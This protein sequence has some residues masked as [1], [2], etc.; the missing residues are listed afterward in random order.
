MVCDNESEFSLYKVSMSLFLLKLITKYLARKDRGKDKLHLLIHSFHAPEGIFH[1]IFFSSLINTSSQEANR[2]FE[3]NL[4]ILKIIIIRNQSTSAVRIDLLGWRTDS[5]LTDFRIN[6]WFF[7]HLN[8]LWRSCNDL[9]QAKLIAYE[10]AESWMF[11]GFKIRQ[12]SIPNW[13]RI[14]VFRL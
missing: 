14:P 8:C 7:R 6:T 2:K 1:K 4:F 12:E 13:F 11:L 3:N 9:E 5:L 10:C